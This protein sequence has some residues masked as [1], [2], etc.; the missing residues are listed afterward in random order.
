MTSDSARETGLGNSEPRVIVGDDGR[1]WI[2]REVGPGIYDRRA[3][4]S[5]VFW[6]DDEIMRRVRVFPEHWREL[7]DS[8]LY[9]LTLRP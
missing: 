9:A 8:E 5:L 2:V 3:S 1:A 4:T 6:S 7:T